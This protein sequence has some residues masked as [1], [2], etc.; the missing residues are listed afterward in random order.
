MKNKYFLFAGNIYYP[1]RGWR[2]FEGEF[3]TIESA[4]KFVEEKFITHSTMWANISDGKRIVM[5]GERDA[6]YPYTQNFPWEWQ[7]VE[8]D[9]Q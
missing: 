7:K 3:E 5:E 4:M 6:E 9:E 8:E 2:D 1:A